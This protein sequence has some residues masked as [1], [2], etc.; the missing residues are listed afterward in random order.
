MRIFDL[1]CDTALELYTQKE[2]LNDNTLAISLDK[3]KDFEKWNQVF[4]IWI[5]DNIRGEAAYNYYF[6][7]YNNF[8]NEIKL[9]QN[10]ISIWNSS[11]ADTRV[12]A[13]MAV[14]G[15]AVLG[16]NIHLLD[17]LNGQGIKI[18]TLT[19]NGENEIG[20]GADENRPLKPFGREVVSKMEQLDMIV[21]V[22]HLSEAGFC[23]VVEI[24]KKPFIASHSNA[25]SICKHRRNL[26]NHQIE[27][28]IHRKGL[29]GL[30]FYWEFVTEKQCNFSGFDEL[31]AHVDHFLSMGAEDVLCLG[32]DFDGAQPIK[33]L[34]DFSKMSDLY[35]FLLRKNYSEHLVD[36]IFFDNANCFFSVHK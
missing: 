26:K 27:E 10:E 3:G 34:D 35:N 9:N 1:H 19:W 13:I 2:I 17:K 36:K 33:S 20:F 5:P 18:I 21:D 12:K 7:A 23:D 24:S 28:I 29:I 30:N 8:L 25:Y 4:A 14:E 6:G 22:S 32:S 15:G 31:F 16:G 11:D